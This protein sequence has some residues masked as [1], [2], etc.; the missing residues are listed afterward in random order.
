MLHSGKSLFTYSERISTGWGGE[1]GM[2]ELKA[3]LSMQN[4][5][6]VCK[7]DPD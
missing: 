1:M 5:Y 4:V 3:V 6:Y 7:W 2:L